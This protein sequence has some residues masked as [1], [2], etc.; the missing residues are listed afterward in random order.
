MIAVLTGAG[1]VIE[2]LAPIPN[3]PN[4]MGPLGAELRLR[5]GPPIIVPPL[6]DA[7]GYGTILWRAAGYGSGWGALPCRTRSN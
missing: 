4:V 2:G 7:A 1:Y 5:G 3:D 6:S